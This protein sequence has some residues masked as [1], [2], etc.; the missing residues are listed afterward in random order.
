MK[1]DTTKPLLYTCVSSIAQDIVRF[2]F[3]G[4]VFF[5][6]GDVPF[7]EEKRKNRKILKPELENVHKHTGLVNISFKIFETIFGPF[8]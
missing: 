2:L 7:S 8:F 4:F 1:H 5:F 6:G 3:F